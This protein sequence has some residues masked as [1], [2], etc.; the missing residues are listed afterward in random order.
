MATDAFMKKVFPRVRVVISFGNN[1]EEL[2]AKQLAVEATA[3]AEAIKAFKAVFQLAEHNA[4]FSHQAKTALM[5][6]VV[7]HLFMQARTD[8]VLAA[9]AVG[10]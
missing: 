4:L 1:K 5:D 7:A 2:A 8:A 6:K 3:P 10:H 9:A